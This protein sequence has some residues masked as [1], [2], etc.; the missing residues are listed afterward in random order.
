MGPASR[1]EKT[2]AGIFLT[3]CA[4][5]VTTP[6]HGIDITVSALLGSVALLLSGVL[7]WEDVASNRAAWDIFVWYG[8]LLQLGKSLNDAGLTREFAR[9]VGTVLPGSGWLPLLAVAIAIYFYSHYAFASITAH[10]LAM[11]T[12]FSAVLIAKGAPTG[13]VVFAFACA[14]NLAAGLTHYGTTPSPMFFAQNY[15]T[16][17]RWWTVGLIVSVLNLAVWSTVGVAWWKLIGLW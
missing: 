8:G 3:V 17:R 14:T 4:L 15:V 13:L 9:V 2:V 6:L 10:M 1:A 7:R 5:W 12:P 16:F 11:F